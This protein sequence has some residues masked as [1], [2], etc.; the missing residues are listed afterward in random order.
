MSNKES[1]GWMMFTIGF[2]AAA[3]SSMRIPPLWSWFVPSLVIS[4]IGAYIAR[5]GAHGSHTEAP[6]EKAKGE[7]RE[8]QPLLENMLQEVVAIDPKGKQ[9][10]VKA[11]IEKLQYG[12]VATFVGERRRFLQKYG[13]VVFAHFFGSFARAERNINR[14]WSALIDGHREELAISLDYA[15]TSI[16]QSLKALKEE[17]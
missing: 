3:A 12:L 1:F 5:I 16:E 15:K 10:T 13:P 4:F 9:D 17:A 2:L 7:I 14:S 6:D 8:A 11:S